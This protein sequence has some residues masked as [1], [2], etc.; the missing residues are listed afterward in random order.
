MFKWG[1]E[2]EKA[3]KDLKHALVSPPA[4]LPTAY[5][6]ELGK[7]PGRIVLGINASHLGYGA[8]LQQEDENG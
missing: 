5:T 8:I 6:A 1:P 2:Q 7:T 3:M 4:L